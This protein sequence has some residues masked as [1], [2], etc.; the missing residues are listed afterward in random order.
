MSILQRLNKNQ[1]SEKEQAVIV[2]SKAN[3]NIAVCES[4]C[5]DRKRDAKIRNTGGEMQGRKDYSAA[6]WYTSRYIVCWNKVQRFRGHLT[7][8]SAQTFYPVESFCQKVYCCYSLKELLEVNFRLRSSKT[9]PC[10][11]KHLWVLRKLPALST[12]HEWWICQSLIH[13]LPVDF[14]ACSDSTM[15]YPRGRRCAT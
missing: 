15:G 10:A 14:R 4:K 9:L 11:W 8:L 12:W 2:E 7:Q 1:R 3:C 5:H 6:R 13:K